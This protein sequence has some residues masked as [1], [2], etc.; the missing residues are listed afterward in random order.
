V[1]DQRRAGAPTTRFVFVPDT[2]PLDSSARAG[3]AGRYWS[4][5]LST[6]WDVGMT[7]N[8]L[9]VRLDG[10]GS[11]AEPVAQ[12]FRDGFGSRLFVMR[13]DRDATGAVSGFRVWTRGTRAIAFRRTTSELPRPQDR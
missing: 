4:E 6:A 10:V 8:S 11:V 5:E 2:I 9:T 7:D 12:Q 13:F 3:Y 1:L